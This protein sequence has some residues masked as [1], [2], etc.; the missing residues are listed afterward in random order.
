MKAKCY[1]LKEDVSITFTP[2]EFLEL[3]LI[4]EGDKVLNQEAMR[5]YPKGSK[6]Y[7]EYKRLAEIPERV[8]NRVFD[9]RKQY[10][11]LEEI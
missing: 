2:E 8:Q 7:E 9:I 4:C 5:Q 10:G 6:G 11:V 3:I 1:V